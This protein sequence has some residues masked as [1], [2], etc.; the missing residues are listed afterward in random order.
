MSETM[1]SPT[2]KGK[3]TRLANIK[4]EIKKLEA[5]AKSVQACIFENQE[6]PLKKVV[7]DKHRTLGL[8]VRDNWS[9]PHNRDAIAVL[10]AK[11]FLEYATITKAQIA[12]AAGEEAVRTL[13][14][15]GKMVITSVTKY[16]S[17]TFRG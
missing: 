11:L 16:Y 13:V 2:L 6:E 1:M 3:Y 5:E 12:K 7:I 14:N 9:K 15:T 8:T 4:E 17:L 10:G